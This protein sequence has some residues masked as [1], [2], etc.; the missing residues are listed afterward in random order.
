VNGGDSEL[1]PAS[2]QAVA[3]GEHKVENFLGVTAAPAPLQPAMRNSK[4]RIARSSAAVRA[5]REDHPCLSTGSTRGGCPGYVI[6][7]RAALKHG[8]NDEP[9]NMQW[10]KMV[11]AKVKDRTE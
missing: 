3:D 8:G 6:D 11:D 9:A 10:Q 2:R 4:G 1:S 7:H 5:F